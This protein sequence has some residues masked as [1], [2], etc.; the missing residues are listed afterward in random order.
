MVAHRKR[1][2]RIALLSACAILTVACSGTPQTR[3]YATGT[4]YYLSPVGSDAASGTSPA[5]AWRTI[6][7][8]NRATLRPGDRLLLQGGQQFPGPLNLTRR[9]AGN[10]SRPLV[11]G[12]YGTRPATITSANTG[13]YVHDTDNVD[14]T[15][16][17]VEGNAARGESAGGSL[18]AGIDVHNDLAAGHRLDH[19]TISR[20]YA[21]GFDNGIAISGANPG[22]GFSDVQVSDCL[23]SGNID[24]GLESDG[25]GFNP[26]SPSYANQNIDVSGVVASR[27]YGNPHVT[28]HNT[29]NGIV[30]GSVQGGR[31]EWSTSDSNG[32]AGGAT[33]QG[34]TGIWTYDSTD[35]VIEHSFSYQTETWNHSDGN[36]FGLDQNTS[37][38]IMQ[39]D[40]SY[41]NFGSGFLVYTG[42][43]NGHQRNNVVRYNISSTDSRDEGIQNGGIKVSGP[44]SDVNVSQN[45][46]VMTYGSKS[47][48]PALRIGAGVTG[49]TARN[50][51]FVTQS[52]PIIAVA[53][54]LSPA[55]ATLQGNDYFSTGKT[56]SI[57]WGPRTYGSLA[58]WRAA[59]AEET[60]AHQETGFSVNPE[61][62]GPLQGLSAEVAAGQP[63]AGDGFSLAA[64]SPL[65]GAG[66]DLAVPGLDPV[67]LNYAGER[68]SALHPN[69]GAQ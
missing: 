24:A 54:A 45:T 46:A 34:P 39:Y 31:I 42:L 65:L 68:Q 20:V 49:I 44:V 15:D 17:N 41:G 32:G 27:N 64:G 19:V 52:R 59:T 4:T 37:D 10:G 22:A 3:H 55:T 50:N 43:A 1:G 63:K 2:A 26:R 56:W 58:S 48:N 13:I 62:I 5:K 21:T 35:V 57:Q 7:R 8:A 14:I 28:S 12:S 66:L 11:I 33:T 25:P 36:G 38:S 30:L 40:L 23:V 16:V 53:Q 47:S 69:V 9:D 60:A 29:G 67:S 18:G 51:I 6:G 61:M